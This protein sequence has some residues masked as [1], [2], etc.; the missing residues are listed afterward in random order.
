MKNY[1][2]TSVI[3]GM[4]SLLSMKFRKKV[5]GLSSNFACWKT[6]IDKKVWHSRWLFSMRK[7]WTR[8]NHTSNLF[9][10]RNNFE[11]SFGSVRGWKNWSQR[12]N[13]SSN[14]PHSDPLQIIECL[15]CQLGWQPEKERQFRRS[16]NR[17]TLR[18]R[19]RLLYPF[20]SQ[21]GK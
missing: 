21:F 10:F 1:V 14:A 3:D 15:E 2:I 13:C 18:Q 17:C 16:A 6:E 20:K 9:Q 8:F 5:H 11:I 7:L 19:H 12:H 4:Q